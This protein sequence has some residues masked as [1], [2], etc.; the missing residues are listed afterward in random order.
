MTLLSAPAPEGVDDGFAVL[1][2][3]GE[4][5]LCGKASLAHDRL[6]A[7][8]RP[9]Q[10]QHLGTCRGL[11]GLCRFKTSPAVRP[12]LGVGDAV[13]VFGIGGTRLVAVAQQRTFKPLE[14]G[15]YVPVLT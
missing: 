5:L 4:F 9:E 14:K 8:E 10:C 6:V 11:A 15:L 7:V 2:A 13:F 3:V 1:A 12:A